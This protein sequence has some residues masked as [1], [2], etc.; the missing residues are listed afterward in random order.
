MGIHCN[1]VLALFDTH[2]HFDPAWIPERTQG[3]LDRAAAAGVDRLIAVG[4]SPEANRLAVE[5]ARANPHRV[6]AAVGIDRD[7]AGTEWSADKL[8]V[9]ISAPETVAV[10]EVGLDFHSPSPLRQAQGF[11]GAPLGFA[12]QNDREAQIRLFELMLVI[13]GEQRL[14]AIVHSREAERETLACLEAHASAWKGPEDRIGVQ[15]CFTGSR[16][17]AERLLA[18]GFYIS[19]SGILTFKN[20]DDLRGIA[21]EIPEVRLL[22]ETDSPWLAPE[23]FRGQP[24]EPA[25]VRRVAETLAEIRHTSVEEIAKA[26][27][28][29][30]EKLFSKS[31]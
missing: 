20:A 9:L 18:L 1:G 4:G 25:H 13:A 8:A 3:I 16:A 21:A 28:R 14:P 15:H 23:P 24:N 7:L 29:N 27:F 26:T 11:G 19:F 12:M 17:Y 5:I 10:G 31:E 22:I 2:V 30:A 6:R